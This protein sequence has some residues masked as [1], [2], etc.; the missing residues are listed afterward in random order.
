MTG[1]SENQLTGGFITALV[2]R[3]G[4][5][6]HRTAG[7][8]SPAVHAWLAHLANAGLD[9]GPRPLGLDLAAGT[10]IVS[11]LDGAVL[12][13]GLSTPY[14]WSESTLT[15]VACLIR[16]F[17]DAAAAFNPPTDAA[18]QFTAA[19]PDG[20][21]VICHNDLAPWNTVFVDGRP[22]AFIDWDLAAPGPRLWDV[23]FAL[24]HFVP[25]YGDPGSDPFAPDQFE[26][27]AA[28]TR[29]FCDA[30]G[31]QDRSMLIDM[32]LARQLAAYTAVEQGASAGDPAYAR[33]WEM[34]AGNGIQRQIDYVRHH[35]AELERVLVQ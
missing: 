5:T 13:G 20:G 2:K 12:S 28:R 1:S 19:H 22:V 24:W 9:V 14:L 15:A 23:A 10:E 29:L 8:W 11:Y 7:P 34:G 18:W 26:P 16:R 33:L 21:D 31:L 35:R 6:V 25:L 4:N 17:H 32:V 30:Y 3:V 27:R